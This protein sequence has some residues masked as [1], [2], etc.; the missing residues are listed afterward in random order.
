M[1]P[2][3]FLIGPRGAGKTSLG[4]LMAGHLGW[5]FGD[6]DRLLEQRHGRL[7]ADW[8]PA[9]PAGFRAAESALLRELVAWPE[10][11]L[12]LGGGVV[13]DPANVVLL[14]AQD[15]VL[16][17]RASSGVLAERQAAEP[18]PS[19]TGLPLEQE[20]DELFARRE[21]AYDRAARGRWIETTGFLDDALQL[22][23]QAAGRMGCL[24][25]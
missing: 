13:E 18:R 19:L 11:V 3:L 22:L 14:A 12:A 9:D 23:L 15:R 4:R 24:N 17:L 20:V 1:N 21:S 8:L 7:I 16:A 5:S 6:S 10:H 25:C 2:S